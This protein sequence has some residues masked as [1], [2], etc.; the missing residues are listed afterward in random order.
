M[1]R[2]WRMGG[3]RGTDACAVRRFIRRFVFT[4]R[5][6]LTYNHAF[7][8]VGTVPARP[9][10]GAGAAPAAWRASAMTQPIDLQAFD[11]FEFCRS[12][13]ALAGEVAA[14]ELPRIIA[15]TSGDA[16]A[17]AA[18]EMFRYE[19][20]ASVREEA[21]EPGTAARRR[22]FVDL[23]VQGRMWLDCQRCLQVYAEPISTSTRFEIVATEAEADAAPM[24]DDDIDVIAGSRRF[25]LL[26]LIED[27]ILLAL[28]VAPKHA[29]CPAVHDSLVTGNDGSV[30]A[31]EAAEPEEEKRPSPFAALASLK[32]RH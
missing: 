8:R 12:G 4:R 10:A 25:D 9:F 6:D 18:N 5:R 15:E 20:S 21:A 13:G 7:Y 28:P 2:V 17:S 14:R 30:E 11:I 24:D 32:T 3:S 29:V 1:R 27:E 23:S 31:D 22:L 26:A 19:M 16:P